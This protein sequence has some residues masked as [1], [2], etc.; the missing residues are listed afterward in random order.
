MHT[1][2]LYIEYLFV[3]LLRCYFELSFNHR[4]DLS[5]PAAQ[6]GCRALLLLA[7]APP[8]TS[9]KDGMAA[10]AADTCLLIFYCLSGNKKSSL[11]NETALKGCRR[12]ES[13]PYARWTHAP[14]TCASTNS[15]TSAKVDNITRAGYRRRESNPHDIAITGFWVQR[16]YQFRHFGWRFNRYQ[17]ALAISAVQ[18]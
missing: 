12:W 10:L 1:A 6:K 11:A 4:D 17:I 18:I 16:V 15:A 5:S 8:K 3:L 2:H 14:E 13:N 9:Y 7:I